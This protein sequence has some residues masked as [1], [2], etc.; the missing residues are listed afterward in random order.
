LDDQ[1][2]VILEELGVAQ[3]FLPPVTVK[4]IGADKNVWQQEVTS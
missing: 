3:F 2:R 1:G 4:L